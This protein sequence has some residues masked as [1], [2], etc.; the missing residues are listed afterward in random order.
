[1]LFKY[2]S[3][4]KFNTVFRLSLCFSNRY[5]NAVAAKLKSKNI[6][7]PHEID[8]SSW[9][10]QSCC[11]QPACRQLARSV[12]VPTHSTS[13]SQISPMPAS[14]SLRNDLPKRLFKRSHNKT[15]LTLTLLTYRLRHFPFSVTQYRY[16]Y[17]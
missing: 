9:C 16:S 17:V 1:V 14:Y 8:T 11:F 5:F 7:M 4:R 10:P 13:S 12:S 15:Y 2:G 6:P 3:L